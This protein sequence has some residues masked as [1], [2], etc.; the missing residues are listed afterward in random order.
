MVVNHVIPLPV[1]TPVFQPPAPPPAPPEPRARLTLSVPPGARVWLAGKEIDAA[2]SPVV[3][4]S[5]A[6]QEGQSYAFDVR[7][8]W[9][10]GRLTEERARVVSVEAGQSKSLTYLAAR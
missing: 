10:E 8:S 1:P 3:L 7:V 6:L 2:A 9:V 5:P 4:D